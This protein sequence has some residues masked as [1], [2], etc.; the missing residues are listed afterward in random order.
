MPDDKY[1]G[2]NLIHMNDGKDHQRIEYRYIGGKDYEKSIGYIN[3][4]LNKFI[5][6]LHK[7]IGS[8]FTNDDI[9]FLEKYLD[10]NINNFKNFSKYDNFIVEFPS[11]ILQIDQN[12]SYDIVNAYYDRI[13]PILFDL[14]DS[15]NS[16]EDCIINFV[17]SS[18]KIEIVDAKINTKKNIGSI[19][20]INCDIS[21]GIFD[22]CLFSDC[23]IL[24]SQLIKS[25]IVRCEIKGSKILNC[26]SESSSL[27]NC[28]LMG[29][30]INSDMEGGVIRSG[31]IGPYANISST[32]KIVSETD[33]FFRTNFDDDQLDQKDG[34]GETTSKKF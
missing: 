10:E 33:N 34:G 1:Y 32:T 21:E 25:S 24:N 15:T 16:L 19:D 27:I 12:G 23:E 30:Y 18:N 26:E 20:F 17:S 9:V 3:Y 13:Y 2:I 11:I 8:K 29:G 6:T 4:F 22:K 14:I 31:K 7:S 28:F 5:I